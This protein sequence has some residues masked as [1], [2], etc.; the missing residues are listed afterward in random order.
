MRGVFDD[1]E[2]EPEQPQRDVEL[3]L[4]SMTLL[5]IFFG[6]VL[7]CGLC[8]GMGYT[9]GRRGSQQPLAAVQ[10]SAGAQT[11]LQAG[12]SRPKPSATAPT[13]AA[14]PQQSVVVNLPPS[15]APGTNPAAN[16]QS[17]EPAAA[18]VQPQVRPALPAVA[19]PVQSAQPA[20][21]QPALA[22][23]VP[24]MVQIA[25]V[26]HEE[27]AEVL[28]SALRNRGYAVS[29]RREDADGLIHVR[30]GPF[31]SRDIANRWRLKLLGDGYNAIVQP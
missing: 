13:G 10:P 8:F 19:S 30:V 4:G 1:E 25:A 28:V 14:P 29:A 5:A 15:S 27:D 22:S 17:S 21:M 3:T 26:S 23:A 9:L 7:L 18:S 12:I 6:L 20:A 2:P 11:A 24:L 31:N 16:S